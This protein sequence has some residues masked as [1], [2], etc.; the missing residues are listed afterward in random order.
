MAN[1][2]GIDLG[3]TYSA[4][5]HLTSD[6]RSEIV[7]DPNNGEN[8]VPSVVYFADQDSVLVG[9][10]AKIE[11][12]IQPE[13]VIISGTTDTFNSVEDIKSRLEQVQFF[14]KVTISSANLDRSGNEVRFM[15]KVTL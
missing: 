11:S 4:V 15:L 9:Y 13:N 2:I 12:V 10:E 5:A 8:L 3:T 1:I 7:R 6:G 14:E